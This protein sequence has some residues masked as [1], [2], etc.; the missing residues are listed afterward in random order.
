MT[1]PIPTMPQA[2]SPT[3]ATAESFRRQIDALRKQIDR[4]EDE[5]EEAERSR[6]SA[7]HDVDALTGKVSDVL[8][9]VTTYLKAHEP[10][11]GVEYLAWR[12]CL[13]AIEKLE[14]EL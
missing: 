6:D 13:A 10:A 2:E 14:D 9:D 3:I 5:I 8:S 4:L 1:E 12:D 11:A 7:D